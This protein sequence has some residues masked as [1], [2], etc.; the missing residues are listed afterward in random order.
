MTGDRPDEQLAELGR[1]LADQVESALPG[2]VTRCVAGVLDA[3]EAAGGALPASAGGRQGVLDQ[4]ARRGRQ[5]AADVGA[6]LRELARS[7]VDA[8]RTTPLA[9]VRST[10]SVPTAVLAEAGVPPIE[11]DRFAT[12]RFP[13]DDYGIVPG[14]LAVLD[15]ELGPLSIAWGAAKAAAHRARHDGTTS[16]G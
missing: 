3:Y 7:D 9:V 13:D 6:A 10:V 4:A 11:R 14:S 15:P 8:M 5:A 16:G 2:W 12:D 1:A